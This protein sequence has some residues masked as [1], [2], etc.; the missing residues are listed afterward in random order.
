MCTCDRWTVDECVYEY[1]LTGRL[2]SLMAA[3]ESLVAVLAALL[4]NTIYPETLHF[5]PG[6]S[7]IM[8]AAISF[9]AFFI[10]V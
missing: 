9:M 8:A 3:S 1:T 5:F 2:F 6:F 4:F 7:F 10:V